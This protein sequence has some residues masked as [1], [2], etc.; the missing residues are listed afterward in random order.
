MSSSARISSVA[1]VQV[2]AALL[3]AQDAQDRTLGLEDYRKRVP[4]G[5]RREERAGEGNSGRAGRQVPLEAVTPATDRV[6]SVRR[7]VNLAAVCSGPPRQ[8]SIA[9][10]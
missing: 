2:P 10:S 4:Q 8:F 1:G 5:Q 3:V 9:S 6:V 7:G